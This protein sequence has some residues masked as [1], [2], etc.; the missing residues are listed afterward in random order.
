[1]ANTPTPHKARA[2]PLPG[3]VKAGPWTVHESSAPR[4][5]LES[6]TLF[7]NT[8]DDVQWRNT[9]AHELGHIK[10]TPTKTK[11]PAD[12][13][14]FTLQAIEDLRINTLLRK[15]GIDLSAGG[16]SHIV[17]GAALAASKD[18]G[19]MASLW[20]ADLCGVDRSQFA[21]FIDA[22]NPLR[23]HAAEI[24]AHAAHYMD[25]TRLSRKHGTSKP[26]TFARTLAV[27]KIVD[28]LIAADKRAMEEESELA[29]AE[30]L[31]GDTRRTTSGKRAKVSGDQYSKDLRADW[32]KMWLEFPKLAREKK[33]RGVRCA[34]EGSSLRAPW[35]L[36]TD[37]RIFRAIN[38]AKKTGT[39]LMDGSGSMSVD[40][41]TI[42]AFVS[43]APLSRVA[44]YHGEGPR[45]SGGPLR[46]LADKG[47]IAT[48]DQAFD[49][50]GGNVVDGPALQWLGKQARPR[51]W[52]CDGVVTG[53]GDARS[54]E[55]DTEANR[56]MKQYGILRFNRCDEALAYL[57]SRRGIPAK[58]I[59]Y[60]RS[61]PR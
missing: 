20:A 24:A 51:I 21:M 1:M 54:S 60:Y 11:L 52:V 29:E 48:D 9:R 31:A 28:S 57:T 55:R 8:S 32:G 34:D 14:P 44:A 42:K 6:K 53:P 36:R 61:E 16:P 10:W 19:M 18:L 23:E 46:L 12:I 40:A 27:A 5:N 45:L 30:R 25:V 58:S 56:L 37:G 39:I 4:V 2:Y 7:V 35:R 22:D 43:A 26:Y 3:Q 13:N 41:D 17:Q 59:A 38:K 49:F 47:K 15:S 50:G 33:T